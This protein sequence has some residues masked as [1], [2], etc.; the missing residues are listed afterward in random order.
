MEELEIY[1]WIR[2]GLQG[3]FFYEDFPTKKERVL[4]HPKQG[5]SPGGSLAAAW[6]DLARLCAFTGNFYKT[7]D[8]AA[9]SIDGTYARQGN[10]SSRPNLRAQ[11]CTSK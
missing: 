11:A 1:F 10:K 6:L 8:A 5:A 9:E 4:R 7:I 2:V 3:G